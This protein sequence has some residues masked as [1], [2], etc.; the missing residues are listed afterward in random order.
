MWTAIQKDYPVWFFDAT[1]SVIKNVERQ[2]K[3][4]LYSIAMYDRAKH[5]LVSLADFVTTS[6]SSMNICKFLFTI[7]NLLNLYI[8]KAQSIVEVAPIFV[9]DHSMTLINAVLQTFNNCS[10]FEYLQYTFQLIFDGKDKQSIER[11]LVTKIH[12]CGVHF[13]NII[14]KHAKLVTKNKKILHTFILF[15]TLLQ[16]STSI[17]QFERYLLHIFNVLNQPKMN[18]SVIV[19]LSILSNELRNR[20]LYNDVDLSEAQSTN[21]YERVK[22]VA[23]CDNDLNHIILNSPFTLYF[24]KLI[25]KF[26][27]ALKIISHETLSSEPVNELYNTLLFKILKDRLYHISMWTGLLISRSQLKNPAG[28]SITRLLDNCGELYFRIIK[29]NLLK[30]KRVMASELA[31]V[32][33]TRTLAKYYEFYDEQIEIHSNATRNLNF[34]NEQWGDKKKKIY[35]ITKAFT[36][37]QQT[38]FVTC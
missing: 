20:K 2:K 11:V 36:T 27:A 33:Y 24:D 25:F 38:S 10:I 9:T 7:K 16:N 28:G 30:R 5:V 19:S 13:I 31:G 34:Q 22:Y 1:G 23:I 21:D 29:V 32:I 6:H 35:K 8:S 4:L 12:I 18:S 14:K 3:P 37:S 26:S 17:Q 15:F